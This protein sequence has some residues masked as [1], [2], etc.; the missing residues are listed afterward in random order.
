MLLYLDKYALNTYALE[1]LQTIFAA[2]LLAINN[3]LD[4]RLNNEL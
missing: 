3:A 1:Q 2:V 4:T